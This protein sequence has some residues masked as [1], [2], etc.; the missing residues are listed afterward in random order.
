[1]RAAI[2]PMCCWAIWCHTNEIL[3]KNNVMKNIRYK[4][5][6]LI[7]D[8]LSRWRFMSKELTNLVDL[9]SLLYTKLIKLTF[10]NI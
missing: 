3:L 1:M 10:E 6:S 5:C 4:F 7:H 8:Y 2:F 9:Y